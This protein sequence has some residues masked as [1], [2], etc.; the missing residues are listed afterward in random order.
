MDEVTKQQKDSIV[1]YAWCR[2][3]EN[4]LTRYTLRKL[5]GTAWY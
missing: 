1:I 5:S 4:L 2:V 3:K